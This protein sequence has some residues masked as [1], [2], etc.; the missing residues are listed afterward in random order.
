[1]AL[2]AICEMLKDKA[3][4]ERVLSRQKGA[5]PAAIGHLP[6]PRA[7]ALLHLTGLADLHE[8]AQKL[9]QVARDRLQNT[10]PHSTFRLFKGLLP[11]AWDFQTAR[12]FIFSWTRG[13]ME[14]DRLHAAAQGGLDQHE[15]PSWPTERHPEEPQ[16]ATSTTTTRSYLSLSTFTPSSCLPSRSLIGRPVA[17]RRCSGW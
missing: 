15:Q 17:G 7:S 2:T 4:V 16:A 9:R 14:R 11:T 13:M 10:I 5:V 6:P 8:R 3:V 12:H 1:M